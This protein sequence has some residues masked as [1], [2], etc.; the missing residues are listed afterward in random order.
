MTTID[1]TAKIFG[2]SRIG[3]NPT[4]M[5]N[6]VIGH[7]TTEMLKKSNWQ[8]LDFEGARIGDNAII[9][10]N[11]VIYCY[12]EIGDNFVTGHNVVIKEKKQ[13]SGTTFL[14]EQIQLLRVKL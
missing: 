6:V 2:N 9:R 14:L 10:S 8:R 12:V 4:I 11:T 1:D 13:K 7:P 3:K 5:Q